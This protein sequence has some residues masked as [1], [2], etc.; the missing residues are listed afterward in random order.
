[1][2]EMNDIKI[3][4]NLDPSLQAG[5]YLSHPKPGDEVVISGISGAYASSANIYEFQENLFNKV[6]LISPNSSRWTCDHPEVPKFIGTLPNVKDFDASF[7]GFHYQQAEVMDPVGRL[8]FEKI[9]EAIMDAGINLNEIRG[10]KTAIIMSVSVFE[11]HIKWFYI[12]PH[13][14]AL[15]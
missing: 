2:A 1:M 13:P 8:I 4:V 9:C 14:Q 6:N 12:T 11:G 7:F 10:T 3:P 15:I 5:Y